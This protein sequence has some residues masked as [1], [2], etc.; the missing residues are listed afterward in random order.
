[1]D[2]GE[3]F[4]ILGLPLSATPIQIKEAYR[5]LAKVWHPD[6]FGSDPR[7][8]SKAEEKLKQVNEAYQALQT[9]RASRRARPT[10]SSS[11]NY[12]STSTQR[13][14]TRTQSESERPPTPTPPPTSTSRTL[15]PHVPLWAYALMALVVVGLLSSSRNENGAQRPAD[16]AA[17][18]PISQGSVPSRPTVVDAPVARSRPDLP[19]GV[20]SR[21]SSPPVTA[22]A[23]DDVAPPNS[24]GPR[25]D[26]PAGAQ[27]ES[28]TLTPEESASLEAACSQAKYLE[29]PAAYNRCISDQ[30]ARLASAPRRPDFSTLSQPERQSI[31]AA[32]SQAKYLEGPAAYNRCL[33]GQ[34]AQVAA[35]PARPD[36]WLSTP[37]RQ[38]IEA[39]CSQAKYLQG[40][41]AY[42]RCLTDQLASWAAA[43]SRPDLS[44]LSGPERQSIEAA[45]SQAKYLQGPAAYNRCLITQLALLKGHE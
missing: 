2:T 24:P 1:M 17:T 15:W 5:D 25:P 13:T 42:S 21:R 32:C 10:S 9:G 41:A 26:I 14:D 29:G 18:R 33:Q 23:Q 30:K 12:G 22:S 11:R 31:E 35:A 40:A 27:L 20:Q 16:R 45:C 19:L 28:R 43:P 38:S 7:L 34:F 8:R 4:T 44:V 39:A 6:R 37:E 3:A 36:L